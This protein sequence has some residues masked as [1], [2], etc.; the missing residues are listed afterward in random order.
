MPRVLHFS[1]LVFLVMIY[2]RTTKSVWKCQAMLV[3]SI[4]REY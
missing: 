1:A 3:H 2:A 4:T